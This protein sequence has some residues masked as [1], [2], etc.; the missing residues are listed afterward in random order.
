MD[1]VL[2]TET[3]PVVAVDP[4]SGRRARPVL[5]VALLASAAVAV[6]VARVRAGHHGANPSGAPAVVPL[7][8]GTVQQR[9][10]RDEAARDEVTPGDGPTPPA[11]SAG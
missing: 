10:T 6:V 2:L 1:T 4:T 11:V 8:T 7:D 3:A 9:G 5:L